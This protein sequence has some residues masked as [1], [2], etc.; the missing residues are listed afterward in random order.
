MRVLTCFPVEM[1]VD[2][3][4]AKINALRARHQAPPMVWDPALAATAQAWADRGEFTHSM[5]PGVGENLAMVWDQGVN[6][7]VDAS[8]NMWYDEVK[9]YDFS[10]PGY[11]PSTGHFTCLVWRGS[12][13]VG[14]GV[15]KSKNNKF[16]I[17]V[18]NTA[19]AGN[20]IYPTNLAPFKSNVLPAARK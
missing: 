17:V 8:I 18:M 7:A 1:D 5:K 15:A 20:T 10:K 2:K 16:L 6:S 11:H 9:N 14:L 12:T 13:K 19:P 3:T 4:L